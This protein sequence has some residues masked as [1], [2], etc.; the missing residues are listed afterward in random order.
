LEKLTAVKS[1]AAF[2]FREKGILFG[3]V[4]LAVFST[5][6]GQWISG[7]SGAGGAAFFLSWLVVAMLGCAFAVVRHADT[8]AERL[9][10]PLGTLILTLSVTGMEVSMVGAVMLSGKNNPVLARDTMFA[11]VMIVLGGLVGVSL[12]LGAWRHRQQE[13]NLE[14]AGAYLSLIVPLAIFGLVMPDFTVA[15]DG[16]T[17]SPGEAL[18]LTVLCVAIYVLFLVIQTKRHREFFSHPSASHA[19]PHSTLPQPGLVASAFLLMAGLIPVVILAKKLA[20]VLEFGTSQLRLPAALAGVIVAVLILAPEGLSA[21]QAALKNQLQRS[22]N[23]LLGSA[24]ATLALTIP[25]VLTIGL[26]IRQEVH[27][28]LP[29]QDVAILCV[30]LAISVLTFG[31]GRTNL[32]QGAIH[33]LV[34]LFWLTLVLES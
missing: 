11:V 33:L 2:L 14:G 24:L 25:A 20:V 1:A 31:R 18:A 7:L 6:G 4:T 17:Y 32:L 15:T 8:I 10:E 3:W 22:I 5:V 28:G 9:G 34:F 19:A 29:V 30:T 21:I 16:P 13:F 27:L 12:M 23:L 26:V